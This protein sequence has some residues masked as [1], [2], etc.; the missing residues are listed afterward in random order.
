MAKITEEF[1]GHDQLV[2]AGYT[3]VAKVRTVEP[4]DEG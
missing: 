3:T 2:G 1:P 4:Y